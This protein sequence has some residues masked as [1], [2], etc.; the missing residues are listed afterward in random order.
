MEIKLNKS[1]ADDT[2]IRGS[3]NNSPTTANSSGRG[4]GT[5][6]QQNPGI[7]LRS[8]NKKL[9]RAWK[10]LASSK[11]R[12]EVRSNICALNRSGSTAKYYIGY[13]NS[14]SST[15]TSSSNWAKVRVTFGEYCVK[16]Q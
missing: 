3:S 14:S 6:Q 12:S 10:Q 11:I 7:V 16:P 9:W 2:E 13:G 1:I 15:R 8:S 4:R 5:K